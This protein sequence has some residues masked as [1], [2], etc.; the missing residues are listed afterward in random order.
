MSTETLQAADS[1]EVGSY[2]IANYPPFSQW[3]RE[4]LPAIERALDQAPAHPETPLGL[5]LHIPFCRKR[6]RF[7][8]FRVYTDQNARDIERYAQALAREVE[9]LADKPAVAGRRLK[10]VYFGGGTP[11]YLSARQLLSLRERLHASVS[12]NDAEEVTFECEPGTLSL[13]KVKTLKEIGITR[14]SLGVENFDDQILELNGRAHLSPEIFKAYDWIQQVDFPQV[15]IDLIA[16]MIGETDENWRTCIEK[17]RELAPDNITIYQMELP[18]NTLIAKEMKDSGVTSPVATWPT[19]RRWVDTAFE[20]LCAAGYH[21]S[22]AQE[23]VHDPHRDRFVYRDNVWRGADLLCTGVASFGHLQ[24]VHYQNVDQLNEYLESLE[25][26]RLPLNRALPI[27]PHQALIREMVLQLKEGRISPGPFQ[28]KF[29]VN[30][31]EE[32]GEPFARQEA[33]GYLTVA[34]DEI[35]LTR[36]GLLQVDTLLPEYFEPE[37]RAVRYT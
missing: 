10:F 29:G 15:N 13:E 30:I 32:F 21:I 35:I 27:T 28:Q 23:L 24:G 1:T 5:Y 16:G 6:C 14:I 9:L 36:R 3:K 11:S 17:A 2:F 8:Y 22:S 25:S 20:S 26:G 31:L 37:H 7:C 19:K 4:F 18:F 12:W 34:G 33:A